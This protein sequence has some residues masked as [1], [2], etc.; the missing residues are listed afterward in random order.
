MIMGVDIGSSVVDG[1]VITIFI[2]EC[3]NIGRAHTLRRLGRSVRQ[4]RFFDHG[5]V[6]APVFVN[7]SKMQ[8]FNG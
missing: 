8:N 7:G 4:F 2:C 6:I 3:L 5:Q 1:A